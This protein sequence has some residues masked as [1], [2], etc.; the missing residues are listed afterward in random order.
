[1]SRASG[2]ASLAQQVWMS[3]GVGIAA[4]T[5]HL[6]TAFRGHEQLTQGD[7]AIAF[8]VN[9]VLALIS[10]AYFIFLP[11]DAG[12]EVSSHPGR[13]RAR[14]RGPHGRRLRRLITCVIKLLS[15]AE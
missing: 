1:M 3:L 5:L 2:L 6:A 10:L 8:L 15:A 11:R 7:V 4:L 13:R 14:S 12:S 9:A